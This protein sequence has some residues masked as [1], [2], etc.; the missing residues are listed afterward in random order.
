MPSD[1]LFNVHVMPSDRAPDDDSC[2]QHSL[3][4]V[5]SGVKKEWLM[6][7]SRIGMGIHNFSGDDSGCFTLPSSSRKANVSGSALP[8]PSDQLEIIL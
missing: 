8:I 3:K 1:L 4:S 6:L 2:S 5:V 7:S